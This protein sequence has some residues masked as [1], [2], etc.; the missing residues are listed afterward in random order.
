MPVHFLFVLLQI[1]IEKLF[2][3]SM[4]EYQI[5][6]VGAQFAANPDYHFGDPET[7]EMWAR[8]MGMLSE[9]R[10]LR[11]RVVL[12]AEP[13][14]PRDTKAVMARAMGRKIGY[15]CKE[16]RDHVLDILSQSE[17]GMLAGEIDNVVIYKHGYLFITLRCKEPVEIQPQH[18]EINWSI[19]QTDFPHLPE[20]EDMQREEEAAFVLEMDLLPRLEDVN[21]TEL[22]MYLG[23]WMESTRHDLSHEASQR[24]EAYIKQLDASKRDEVRKMAD[25]LKHECTRMCSRHQLE[26]RKQEWWPA[27]VDSEGAEGMWNKWMIQTDGQLLE[28]LKLIDRML[29]QLPGM[30]Y[31]DVGRMEVVFSRIYYH[32]IPRTDLTAILSLLI[33][34]ERTCRQLGIAMKPMTEADYEDC[35]SENDKFSLEDMAKAFLRLPAK[36]ALGL[37]GPVS[38]VMTPLPVW[39]KGGHKIHEKI[40]NKQAEQEEKQEKMIDS[41]EKSLEE[42]RTQNNY[43][44]ELVQKKETNIGTNYGPN[45]ENNGTLSLPDK[46]DE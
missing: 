2:P 40:L 21:L 10:D 19:R 41:V 42:P 44:L 25:E 18:P 24:R 27:L 26:V 16:Q 29:R 15:V 46:K 14:N 12:K 22:Q 33:L 5:K 32:R 23:M 3:T 34:R 43:T 37:Y 38:T 17:R 39:Q 28:G 1:G 7:E 20:T 9:L 30:I 35:Q 6:I 31:Q 4:I 36:E 45:I 11:P 13:T 8:T